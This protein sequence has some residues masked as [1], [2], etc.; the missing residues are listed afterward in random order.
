MKIFLAALVFLLPF[1]AQSASAREGGFVAAEQADPYR[2][3]PTPP[4]PSSP[5][6]DA[7]L[8]ELHRIESARSEA[9]V[10]KAKADADDKTVFLF[11]NV[12]GDK[13]AK[14][15]LPALD[16][17]GAKVARDENEAIEETKKEF[18]RRRPYNSDETL[19]PVCRTTDKDDSYPSGHATLGYVLALTLID[20]VPE[21]RDAILAR[22]D[23]YARSRLICGVHYPSDVAAGRLTAYAIHAV[24]ALNARYREEAA[25]ARAELRRALGTA[26]AD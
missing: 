16:A 14:E 2:H 24:I 25:A 18:H 11:R 8:A 23:D 22:A 6:N 9:D 12:F 21:R 1:A 19:H 3:L 10:A 20:I 5:S 15:N 17:L 13:F 7:E 26:R 4:A